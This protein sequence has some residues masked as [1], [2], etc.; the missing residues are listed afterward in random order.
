MDITTLLNSFAFPVVACVFLALYL[1][2]IMEQSEEDEKAHNK[3]ISALKEEIKEAINK[4]TIAVNTLCNL[5]T[6]NYKKRGENN[7]IK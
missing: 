1:K 7:E 5:I 6:L 3:E 2:K 4:N